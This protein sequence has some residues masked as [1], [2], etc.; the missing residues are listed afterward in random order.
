MAWPNKPSPRGL[1]DVYKDKFLMGTMVDPSI[2]LGS[3][4]ALHSLIF[5]NFSALTT[6]NVFKWDQIHPTDIDWNWAHA[7]EFI[8]FGKEHEMAL[9]GH[10]LVWNSQLPRGLFKG[11]DG[12]T[13]SRDALKDKLRD[14]I[15][16]IIERYDSS[17]YA[18]DVV[19]E[20]FED[21]GEYARSPW[22]EILGAD[23]V[24]YSFS[25][26]SEASR[27]AKLIYNDYNLW[28]PQK[29]H[30][31]VRLINDLKSSGIRIDA[32]G[33]QGHIGLTYPNLKD[34]ENSIIAF[35]QAGVKVHITELEVDV[36]PGVP[37]GAFVEY[38][39]E[40]D[41]YRDGL[42]RSI[43][44]ALANRYVELFKMLLKYSNSIERVT[45]W[46]VTDDQS[47]KN[48]FPVR[49][50]KNHTLL[51]DRNRQPKTAY[52]SLMNLLA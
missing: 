43:D 25:V 13:I 34:F 16:T 27:H 4:D 26:A 20:A 36:L 8:K 14:H 9:I 32:V 17:I 33:M 47:W 30:A 28:R 1:K 5:N 18:W 3:D 15:Q 52:G 45:F 49:G 31:A 21:S 24:K 22:Y 41:P 19:N 23:Y 42:P 11:R 48:D 12:G 46:G 38:S 7:D 50:R 29:R 2:Y 10:P 40:L 44:I 37:R 39:E 35:A 51:F 6:D